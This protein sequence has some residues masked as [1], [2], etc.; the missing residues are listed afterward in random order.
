MEDKKKLDSGWISINTKIPEYEQLVFILDENNAEES[1]EIARLYSKVE[2]KNYVS[3]EWHIGKYGE[4]SS[5]YDITHWQ[6]IL[7]IYE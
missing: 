4:D 2:R 3:Y 7:K 1:F 6:P 5:Y